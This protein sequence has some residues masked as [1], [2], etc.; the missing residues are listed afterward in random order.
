VR[1]VRHDEVALRVRRLWVAS[2]GTSPH[3]LCAG[4]V[5]TK[6]SKRHSKGRS[7]C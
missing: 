6:M 4:A 2:D 1:S 7:G 5:T 3:R